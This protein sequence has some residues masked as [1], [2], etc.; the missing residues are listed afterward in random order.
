MEKSIGIALRIFMSFCSLFSGLSQLESWCIVSRNIISANK[1]DNMILFILSIIY[2]LIGAVFNYLMCVGIEKFPERVER[3]NIT[4]IK[5]AIVS[6]LWPMI[7]IGV[8]IRR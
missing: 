7:I 3:V 2:L 8:L 5:L 4:S 6:L 1:G